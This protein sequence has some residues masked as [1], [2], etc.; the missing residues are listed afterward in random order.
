MP[1]EVA[2]KGPGLFRGYWRDAEAT[3]AAF[4]DGFFLTGDIG[5]LD[6]EGDLFVRDR[7]KNLIISGGENIYPA[8][9]ERVILEFPGIVECAVIGLPD[10]RWQE[11]PVALIVPRPG[12][13]IDIAALQAH[14]AAHL[15]RFKL[16]R[17]IILR[18]DLPKSSLG[19]VQHF[20]LRAEL[21][22]ASSGR[23]S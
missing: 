15:A 5:V 7:K 19:K 14:L 4:S 18:D 2:L 23:G 8:E 22:G 16:P 6:E 20:A 17:E 9:V 10:P 13:R 12:G 21:A 11:R 3:A 1:G